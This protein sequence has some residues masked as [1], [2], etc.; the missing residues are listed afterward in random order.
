MRRCHDGFELAEV[1]V[2]RLRKKIGASRIETVRGLGYRLACEWL[3]G[4]APRWRD[5]SGFAASSSF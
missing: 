2:G 4:V 5:A 3:S 1:I